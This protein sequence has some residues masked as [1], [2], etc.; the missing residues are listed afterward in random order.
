M[1]DGSLSDD[2]HVRE[3]SGINQFCDRKEVHS[4]ARAFRIKS[5]IVKDSP[6]AQRVTEIQS[7]FYG[8]CEGDS[9]EIMNL[10]VPQTALAVLIR[11]GS[12]D[13]SGGSGGQRIVGING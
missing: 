2:V 13:L 3:Q 5:S 11:T 6:P 1:P 7:D 12:E 8:N 9:P 4:E 10:A